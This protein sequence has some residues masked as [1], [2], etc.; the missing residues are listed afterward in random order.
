MWDKVALFL[1]GHLE[2]LGRLALELGGSALLCIEVV[3]SG[4][5]SKDLAIFGHLEPLGK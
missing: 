4:L 2:G 1:W 3:E 5:S